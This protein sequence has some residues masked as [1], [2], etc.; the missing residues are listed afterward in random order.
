MRP[1]DALVAAS[2]ARVMFHDYL[3]S[4]LALQSSLQIGSFKERHFAVTKGDLL[5]LRV[6]PGGRWV[7][8]GNDC[9]HQA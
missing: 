5:R 6:P 9:C 8:S 7:R 4:D 2:M 1:D 3:W